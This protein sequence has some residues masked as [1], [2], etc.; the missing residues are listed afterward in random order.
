MHRIRT[1]TLTALA[2][3]A[4]M[5][6]TTTAQEPEAPIELWRAG[7]VAG[8]SLIG[9]ATSGM[10][11]LPG[12]P[13]CCPGY[14]GGSG[15]GWNLGPA[16]ELPLA[17]RLSGT[18]RLMAAGYGGTLEADEHQL[19]TADRDTVTATFRHTITE[20]QT[21]VAI[22]AL[23]A[24]APVGDLKVFAGPRIDVMIGSSYD[25]EERIME[26]STILY[27]NDMRTRLVYDG[28]L[29]EASTLH[30][31]AV[32]GVRYDIAIN[33]D[34]TLFLSP[35]ISLWKDFTN[36][37]ADRD[38][39]MSGVRFGLGVAFARYRMP[40]QK[41]VL[42]LPPIETEEPQPSGSGSGY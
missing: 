39:S 33:A 6:T 36:I 25:Q 32:V 34:R 17:T 3:A 13:S 27:E 1:I 22:E 7:G 19:V 40:V 15:S 10:T 23:A 5:T 30:L 16:I 2:L 41:E 11:G 14:D 38:W 35:E 29:P 28:S 20:S 9:H 37:V 42:P 18:L 4:L 12:I 31:S 24:Y 8:F 26:P 21:A